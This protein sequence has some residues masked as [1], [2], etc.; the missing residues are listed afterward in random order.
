MTQFRKYSLQYIMDNT[1]LFGI[2]MN[3]LKLVDSPN[4][5]KVNFSSD[6]IKGWQ[7]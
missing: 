5:S 6:Y 3:E 2:V 7:R 1:T 4:F